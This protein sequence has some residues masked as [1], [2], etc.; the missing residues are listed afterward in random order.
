MERRAVLGEERKVHKAKAREVGRSQI[1]RACP[2]RY[3]A[4]STTGTTGSRACGQ[5]V[6]LSP[7]VIAA[8][9]APP[10]VTPHPHT[11]SG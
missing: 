1:C 10:P 4:V 7:Q 8:V 9:P 2:S 11:V 3:G 5:E 6:E